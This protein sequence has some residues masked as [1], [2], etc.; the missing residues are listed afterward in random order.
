MIKT[1]AQYKIMA[2]LRMLEWIVCK[3]AENG[4]HRTKTAR[5][6]GMD[7]ASVRHWLRQAKK[8]GIHV[9]ARKG[10]ANGS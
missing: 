9:P 1:Y 4:G 6:I 10:V 7:P 3:V 8:N 2:R 5:A